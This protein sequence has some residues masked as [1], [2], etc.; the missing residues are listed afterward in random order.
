MGKNIIAFL[1]GLVSAGLVVALFEMLAGLL[2]PLPDNFDKN[3][4]NAMIE[5]AKSAPL[6]AIL[7]VLLAY[8]IGAFTGG[9]VASLISKTR[10]RTLSLLIA[11]IFIATTIMNLMQI[12]H[13]FWFG[14]LAVVV[15]I[16]FSM[17]GYRTA[18]GIKKVRL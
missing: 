3:N 2:H 8:I 17:L 18:A 13:P 5:H 16:P 9:L 15:W 7:V 14:V 11:V 1:A 12:P 6:S 4:A 10:P